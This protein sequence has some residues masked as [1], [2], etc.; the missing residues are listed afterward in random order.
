MMK[1]LKVAA[2][3]LAAVFAM[4]TQAMASTVLIVDTNA[5]VARSAVGKHVQAELKKIAESIQSEIQRESGP[6][7][8]EFENFA[9]E[10]EGKTA[11]QLRGRQDLQQKAM[12]LQGKRQEISQSAAIKQRELVASRAKALEPVSVAIDEI[13]QAMVREKSADVLLERNLVYFASD[14]TDI[15]DEVVRR[16]DAKMK[17]VR[18]ERVRAPA[19]AQ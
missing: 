4:A 12:E 14:S 5:V 7:A 1:I 19:Q 10:L 16:L 8:A 11:E 18:V 15:T 9:K 17:T 3:S 13:L 2:L 6:A